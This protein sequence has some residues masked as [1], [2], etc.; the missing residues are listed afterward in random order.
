[1]PENAVSVPES[2][3]NILL[4]RD[5]L[6][7]TIESPELAAAV[8]ELRAARSQFVADEK[9]PKKQAAKEAPAQMSLAS[10]GLSLK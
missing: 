9:K 8:Q 3:L 6:E 2:A 7:L 4:S 5:P 1:M 10:L